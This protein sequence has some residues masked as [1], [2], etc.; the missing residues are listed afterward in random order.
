M[1]NMK[2]A[3]VMGV[4]QDSNDYP[5]AFRWFV[6]N[7]NANF[8]GPIIHLNWGSTNHQPNLLRYTHVSNFAKFLRFCDFFTNTPGASKD[9]KASGLFE[10][11]W[12]NFNQRHLLSTRRLRRRSPSEGQNDAPRLRR[13]GP[14]Q[15]ENM[16][17]NDEPK[18]E[19]L[20]WGGVSPPQKKTGPKSL[21]V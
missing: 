16:M 12:M 20:K 7:Q 17:K 13:T 9:S 2:P 11:N 10:S 1:V 5:F 6:G 19:E 18:I 14:P 3:K 15:G 8:Q 4:W 21:R